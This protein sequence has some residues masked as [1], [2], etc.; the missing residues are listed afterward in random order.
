MHQ[1][2]SG[3][4]SLHARGAHRT[5]SSAPAP[6]GQS[7]SETTPVTSRRSLPA[8]PSRGRAGCPTATRASP[9]RDVPC[10]PFRAEDGPDAPHRHPRIAT[11]RCI[12]DSL[13]GGPFTRA[14]HKRTYGTCPSRFLLL[15]DSIDATAARAVRTAPFATTIVSG[16]P[17]EP[18]APSAR[19]APTRYVHRAIPLQLG[20]RGCASPFDEVSRPRRH[21][22]EVLCGGA[23]HDSGRDTRLRQG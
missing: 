4:R 12:N 19:G 15:H 5:R 9:R 20:R 8:F 1:R 17:D 11:H 18:A 7:V 23:D 10:R 21:R 22:P 13:A 3:W 2:Q 6:P 16:P 14:G